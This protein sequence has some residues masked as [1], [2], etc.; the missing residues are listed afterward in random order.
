VLASRL[1]E[2]G[3]G[4][5]ARLRFAQTAG[6]PV[7]ESFL[8]MEVVPR[9]RK[10]ARSGQALLHLA[11]LE[12]NIAWIIRNLGFRRDLSRGWKR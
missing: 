9:R 6:F 8:K 11:H 5:S 4:A 7:R 3:T 2:P 10:A 1:Q 12:R